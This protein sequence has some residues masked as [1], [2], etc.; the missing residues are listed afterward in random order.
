M[1][2]AWLIGR[3][4]ELGLSGLEPLH[5]SVNRT[6]WFT[7]GESSSF[8]QPF[9]F[10]V[11]K[12]KSENWFYNYFQIKIPRG[13]IQS[14]P[15]EIYFNLDNSQR[16]RKNLFHRT[17]GDERCEYSYQ[18]KS[19]MGD[20]GE[21]LPRSHSEWCILWHADISVSSQAESR[22]LRFSQNSKELLQ[23]NGVHADSGSV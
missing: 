6:T 9:D 19:R 3:G 1:S 11:E 4:L 7:Y 16:C 12:L 20:D 13:G 5:C 21:R 8:G 15:R 18:G 14:F 23:N 22:A 2:H 10:G 17:T